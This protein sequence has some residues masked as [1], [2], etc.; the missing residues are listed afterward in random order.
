M[1]PLTWVLLIGGVSYVVYRL[2]RPKCPTDDVVKAAVADTDS[3]KLSLLDAEKLAA[4]W[5]SIG[6]SAAA[7]ALRVTAQ[8]RR[9]RENTGPKAMSTSS[10]TMSSIPSDAG[11]GRPEAARPMFPTDTTLATAGIGRRPPFGRARNFR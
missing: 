6:C 2:T 11:P 4:I 7:T 1:E 3:G 9:A 10:A 8:A 5:D